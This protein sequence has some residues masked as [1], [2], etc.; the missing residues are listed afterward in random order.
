MDVPRCRPTDSFDE[1]EGAIRAAGCVV[2]EDVVT[3][4]LMDA[5]DAELSPYIDAT[6]PGADD[7]AGLHTRRTGAL[8]ARSPG[9][10]ELAAHPTVLG[11]LDRVLGHATSYQ[12]H[13]TQVIEIGPDEP[14]QYIHR[15]QWA[16]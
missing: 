13:L 10:R 6:A 3:P 2:V 5:I 12:L 1:L 16:F 15:D 11:V 8:L 14:A 7:F 4:A 9:F